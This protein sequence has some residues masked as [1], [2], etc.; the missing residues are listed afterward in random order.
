M[1]GGTIDN[2][3]DEPDLVE[4]P[5]AHDRRAGGTWRANVSP[6][7]TTQKSPAASAG[8]AATDIYDFRRFCVAR[9][10]DLT[11]VDIAGRTLQIR[12]RRATRRHNATGVT[13]R[14]SAVQTFD[15]DLRSQRPQLASIGSQQRRKVGSREV[16][17]TASG[18]C[19]PATWCR[20]E[21]AADPAHHK[22]PAA[23]ERPAERASGPSRQLLDS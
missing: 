10:V 13:G 11:R 23:A 1:D 7:S 16:L 19:R 15:R 2:P 5:R 14:C 21:D 8:R 3:R 6:A 22:L 18:S 17:A 20:L 12:Q 4:Q 9:A